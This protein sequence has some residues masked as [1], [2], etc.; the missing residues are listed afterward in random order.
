MRID[1][2]ITCTVIGSLDEITLRFNSEE[3]HI[4]S[5]RRAYES[6]FRSGEFSDMKIELIYS[7]V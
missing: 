1:M 4:E 6:A 5:L 2:I 3:H 7:R